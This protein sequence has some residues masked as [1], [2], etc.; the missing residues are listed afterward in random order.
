MKHVRAPK[1]KRKGSWVRY[2]DAL[3]LARLAFYAGK[4]C[5]AKRKDAKQSKRV[6]FLKWLF[7]TS[8]RYSH[9]NV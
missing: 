4:L 9:E 7:K 6:D 2:E 5:E 8:K 3:K 1:T